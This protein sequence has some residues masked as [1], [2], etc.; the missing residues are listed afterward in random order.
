V[1]LGGSSGG[2]KPDPAVAATT[3][4]KP[5]PVGLNPKS[6]FFSHV[7]DVSFARGGTTA[8]VGHAD[9]RGAH[10]GSLSQFELCDLKSGR[11][12]AVVRGPRTLEHLA[13]SPSGQRLITI[14]EQETF[15]SGPL[16]LWELAGEELKHLKSWRVNS[17][18]RG[19]KIE[20][21][22][23]V[24]DERVMTVDGNSLTM[25]SIEG[26]RGMYQVTGEGLK[27]PAFSPGGKQ[28]AV[29]SDSGVSVHEVGTGELLTRIG[30]N[31]SFGRHVAFSPSGKLLAVTGSS[32]VDV[33]DLA[34]GQKTVSAYAASAVSDKGLSWLDEEH[35]L[36]GGSNLIHLPSQMTVWN[37]QHNAES[38]VQLAD[39]MWYVFAELGGES[40]ALLPFDLPHAAVKPVSDSELVLKP[41]DEVSIQTELSFD[42][43]QDPQGNPISVQDQLTTALKD[44]GF[45]VADSSEKKLIARTMSG[46]SKEIAYR[47][48]GAGFETQKASYTQRVFELELVV[49][50][51]S[52]WKRRR[53]MD[54]PYHLQLKENESVDQAINRSLAADTGFFRSTVPSRILPT[55]AEKARTSTLSI[56]GIQ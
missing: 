18:E 13:I 6:N 35:V 16:Q 44:A 34:T 29:G 17:G 15:V 22:G 19:K 26:P 51:E 36:V 24:D 25:W 33:F 21:I 39:R 4:W 1:P 5:S 20:W 14:S 54:A 28:F 11:V 41:G 9:R 31:H 7:I 55:A 46:E 10:E 3:N 45:K 43:G 12:A 37:Y 48:F 38:V 30:M 56:N 52:V 8:A 27:A 2:F 49:N 32:T 23:W 42:L 47:M 40:M 50:G 53:V